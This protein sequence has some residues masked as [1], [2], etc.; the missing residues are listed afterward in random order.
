[1]EDDSLSMLLS[2]PGGR[3]NGP[4]GIGDGSEFP[5]LTP[6]PDFPLTSATSVTTRTLRRAGH[7]TML[8]PAVFL[9][10]RL[11]PCR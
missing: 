5:K 3:E 9:G 1:M 2:Y 6:V 10:L 4:G 11:H 7:R 8:C